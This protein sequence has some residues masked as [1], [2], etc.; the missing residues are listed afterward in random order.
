MRTTVRLPHEL[1]EQAKRRAAAEG[2]T[3]TAL[4]EMGLRTVLTRGGQRRKKPPSISGM[5][6][7]RRSGGLLPGTDPIKF[8]TELEEEEDL[9]MLRRTLSRK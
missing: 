4:I 3:L 7:S 6:I 9:E 1:L 5:P 2:T 8:R